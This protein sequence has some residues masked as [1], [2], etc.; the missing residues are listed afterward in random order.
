MKVNEILNTLNN[1]APVES[2]LAF[3]NVGLLVGDGDQTV[4]KA[5]VCLDVTPAV[6]QYT[7]SLGA[8]LIISHHP[9]IFD[10]LKSVVNEIG[11][12][13]YECLKNNISVISMH[14]NL[15]SA[16]GGVNDCLANALGLKNITSVVDEEGFIFKKGNLKDEMTADGLARYIKSCLGGVVRYTDGEKPIKTVC[17]CGGSGGGLLPIAIECA[18]AFVTG[19]VKHNVLVSAASTKFSV[20]EAGHF[21]TE[22]IVVEPLCA[23]LQKQ[24]S[25][26]EFY[27]FNGKEIKTI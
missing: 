10:P 23:R 18:D 12:V 9:I 4:S 19:E 3:D 27:S 13:V 14:T 5:V 20:F 21:H 25:D 7:I 6:T 1:I 15:D 22:N 24:F 17:V 8:E 2:A 26:I 11:N 16:E